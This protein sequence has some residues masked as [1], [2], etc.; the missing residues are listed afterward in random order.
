MKT[1]T[2]AALF[3]AAAMLP[4]GG[5]VAHAQAQTS[6]ASD[7]EFMAKLRAALK[8]NP[9]IVLE[10][11]QA[12]QQ[13]MQVRQRAEQEAAI[14][15]VRAE[16]TAKNTVGVVI[17]NPNGSQSFVEFL[18]YNCGFCKRSHPEV[19]AKIAQDKNTRF[20]M[21]MRPVLGPSSITLAKYAL[22]A[23]MQGK[24][25]A[26]DEALMTGRN[27]GSDAQLEALSKQIGV[28]WNKARTD[29]NG[30]AVA[31]RLAKHEEYAER[32]AVR[33]TPFFITPTKIIP[34]ATTKEQ[35]N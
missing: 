33:G 17:G 32:I 23:D 35:L 2:I 20:V 11:A 19:M 15:P 29:M 34:G 26:A 24:F 1:K 21:M 18:D 6:Q 27:D 31:T 4:V 13:K 28:D 8:E 16:L 14:A 9:E 25:L 3:L 30:E 12:A 7:P 10:A 5:F 22:A